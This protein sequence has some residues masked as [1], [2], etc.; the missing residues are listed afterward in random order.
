MILLAEAWAG[1]DAGG[2]GGG[3]HGA[4]IVYRDPAGVRGGDAWGSRA[5]GAGAI[6]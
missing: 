3:G 5:D 4:V 2:F 6:S 1:F